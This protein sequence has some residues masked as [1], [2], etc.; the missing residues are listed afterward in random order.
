MNDEMLK[1]LKVNQGRLMEDIHYTCQWG[2]GESWGEYVTTFTVLPCFGC[3]NK[4][5]DSFALL[6]HKG[7][8]YSSSLF[9]VHFTA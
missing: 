2:T 7:Q 1:D 5:I 3:R 6:Q 9:P 8:L 4:T